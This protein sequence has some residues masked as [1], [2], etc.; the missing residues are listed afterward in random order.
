MATVLENILTMARRKKPYVTDLTPNSSALVAINDAFR[1]FAPDLRLWSFYE[2]LPMRSTGAISR[3]IVDRHSATL[4]YHNEEIAGLDADHRQVCK[5]DTPDDPNYK[6]LRNALLTAVDMIRAAPKT[7]TEHLLPPEGE[8]DTT[9]VPSPPSMSPSEVRLRLRALLGVRE[10]WEGDLATLQVLKQ[11]GSCE[12]FA[13]EQ[14][15]ASWR[16]GTGPGILWLLGRPGAGK[17]VLSSHVID[18]LRNATFAYCSYFIC[19]HA[20]AG[21]SSLSDCLRSLA[22]QMA[23]QD[24]LVQE[25]LLQL[26]RD[27]LAWDKADD[28]SVWQRLFTGCIFKLPSLTQ[29]F[30]VVDGLDGCLNFNALFSKR[31]LATLPQGL[32]LFAT[33]RSL[34]K[35]QRGLTSLGSNRASVHHLSDEDTLD[36]M[37]LFLTMGLSHLGR[38][39]TAE[40]R[41]R[42]CNKI[43]Q[44]SSGSFLWARLVLQ[45]FQSAWTEEAMDAVL[46]EIPRDRF[47]LYARMVQSVEEDPR[48]LPLAR[49][50]LTW[51]VLA[52]RP[53]T[54]NEVRCAV[55]LDLNQTLQ[56]PVKAIPDLC[57]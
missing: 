56:N 34:E 7:E 10:T 23:M 30:W 33:S 24:R 4:G 6:L 52:C 55:K 9:L 51:V 2:T 36:D 1:H 32:R 19:K 49:S 54:V 42:M 26:A 44:K 31:M 17:S 5:F 16:A 15:F 13:A 35:M 18:E 53:L 40:D 27:D 29:H 11:P 45:E 14:C 57:G 47:E 28:A 48:K 3:I 46:H 41:E 20:K 38:P 50:I 25:A 37:Q 8:R 43:V 12:W 22:F 39:E 21:E